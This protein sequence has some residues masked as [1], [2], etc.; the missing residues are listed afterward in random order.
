MTQPGDHATRWIWFLD[1]VFGAIVALGIEKYAVVIEQ[2]WQAG[3]VTLILSLLSAVAVCSFVVYDIA[4]Y[5]ALAKK[6]PYRMSKP[7]F[8]RF[9]L[10]L[11]MA[12]ILYM[13]LVSAF[14]VRPEWFAILA[15]ISIWHL[16]AM[17]W[18]GLAR[19]EDPSV[20]L[21]PAI[22]PHLLALVGYWGVT[23]VLA[24]IV[25]RELLGLDDSPSSAVKLVA[26]C[27]CILAFSMLRWLHVIR[28]LA[29]N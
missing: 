16:A 28:Q 22:G 17:S 4:I 14:Q 7:G 10:D 19:F 21:G 18:H 15:T 2:A 24:D 25:E 5:H 29:R 8:A 23:Y 12:F 1:V 11:V 13:L 3:A 26:I 27:A 20:S 6:Y 9:Y